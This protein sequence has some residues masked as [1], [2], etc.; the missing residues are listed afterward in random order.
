MLNFFLIKWLL[1]N[2]YKLIYVNLYVY[3]CDI[4]NYMFLCICLLENVICGGLVICYVNYIK[5]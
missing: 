2:I 3:N 1:V 4:W 5:L